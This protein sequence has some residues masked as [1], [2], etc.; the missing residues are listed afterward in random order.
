VTRRIALVLG[1]LAAAPALA[2]T[3]DD[4]AALGRYE[5]RLAEGS[6]APVIVRGKTL[7]GGPTDARRTERV[8]VRRMIADL[9]AGRPVDPDALAAMLTRAGGASAGR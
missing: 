7:F 8:R 3:A 4:V 6:G 2:A 1:L 9:E 5:R